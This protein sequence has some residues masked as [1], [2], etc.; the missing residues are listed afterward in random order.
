[1]FYQFFNFS[2]NILSHNFIY[3]GTYHNV[4]AYCTRYISNPQGKLQKLHCT[5]I[6]HCTY[7]LIIISFDV[8]LFFFLFLRQFISYKFS[9]YSL[10][11][12]FNRQGVIKPYKRLSN[13]DRRKNEGEFTIFLTA[14]LK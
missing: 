5:I 14:T 9:L 8:S 6:F 10:T 1:M 3:I 11:A 2:T 4:Y 13:M 12:Y 7:L